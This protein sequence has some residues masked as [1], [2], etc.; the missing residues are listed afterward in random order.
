MTPANLEMDTFCELYREFNQ[1][2]K[3]GC[4][5]KSIFQL[6]TNS[7]TKASDL[8]MKNHNSESVMLFEIYTCLLLL[9]PQPI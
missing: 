6:F 8:M 1:I 3:N 7:M 5:N 2:K 9:I 4:I